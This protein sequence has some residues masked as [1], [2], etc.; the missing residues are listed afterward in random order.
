MLIAQPS[1]YNNILE[2]FSGTPE[3]RF[4]QRFKVY[5][6]HCLELQHLYDIQQGHTTSLKVVI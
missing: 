4:D 1:T 5:I 2:R 6:F 3:N